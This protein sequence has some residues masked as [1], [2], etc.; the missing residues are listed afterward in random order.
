MKK[1]TIRLRR[2][3]NEEKNEKGDRGRKPIESIPDG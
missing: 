3:D 1:K 2:S